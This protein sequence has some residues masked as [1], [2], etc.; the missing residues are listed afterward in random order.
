MRV[1]GEI[2]FGATVAVPK[3]QIEL[4]KTH[5]LLE[6][7]QDAMARELGEKIMEEKGWLSRQEGD[8]VISD[9]RLY[10]FTPAE[11]MDYCHAKFKAKLQKMAAEE[12]WLSDHQREA[13]MIQSERF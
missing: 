11:L 4:A 6:Y 5:N 13:L 9:V 2:V 8:I 10:V 7:K 3:E 12:S 1:N